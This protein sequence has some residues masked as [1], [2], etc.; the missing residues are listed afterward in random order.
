MNMFYVYALHSQKTKSLYIGIS[1]DPDKRLKEHNSGATKSTKFGRPFSLIYKEPV[2]DRIVARQREK[3]LKSG[4]GREF[5]KKFI[6][7]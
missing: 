5:L 4:Y 1:A 3:I 7:R 6:R 2:S